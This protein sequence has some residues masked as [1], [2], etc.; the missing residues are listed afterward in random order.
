MTEQ[1]IK[2]VSVGFGLKFEDTIYPMNGIYYGYF[3][4]GLEPVE[5][6]I[7]IIRRRKKLG[8]SVVSDL[9]LS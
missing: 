9:S 1:P 3:D 6:P 5:H 4:T 2:I 8:Y 7:D